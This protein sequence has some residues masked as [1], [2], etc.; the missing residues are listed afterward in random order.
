MNNNKRTLILI[1][2]D[3][4]FPSGVGTQAKELIL[5]TLHEYNWINIGVG[6]N[7]P[8]AGKIVDLSDSAKQLTGVKDASLKIYPANRY[9]DENVIFAVI[10]MENPQ[11]LCMITDPR[12]YPG[13]FNIENQI[14]AKIPIVYWALW[15]TPP[16]PNWNRASYCSCDAILAISQQSNNLHKWVVRPE[17]CCSLSGEFDKSGILIK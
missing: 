1:S 5:S 17:N 12:F 9:D 13:L 11:A 6:Q 10:G 7:H 14:R 8:E 16:Y 3:I 15:D 2:D 4:R